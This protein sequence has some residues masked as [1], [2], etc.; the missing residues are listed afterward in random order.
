M[1]KEYREN[2]KESKKK[3]RKLIRGI[4]GKE[5]EVLEDIKLGVILRSDEFLAWS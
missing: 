4:S 5:K 2:K 3:S 1:L